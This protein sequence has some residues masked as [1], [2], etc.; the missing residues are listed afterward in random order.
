MEHV[1][2]SMA[3][4]MEVSVN[5]RKTPYHYS[6][7]AKIVVSELRWQTDEFRSL[8]PLAFPYLKL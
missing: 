8:H 3:L 6:R 5:G 7:T 2:H 1:L 4:S